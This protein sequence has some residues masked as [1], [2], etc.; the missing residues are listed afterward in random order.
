MKHIDY[1]FIDPF[2]KLNSGVSTYTDIA[3]RC[4]LNH[5][6]NSEI[7][8]ISKNE[9][10]ESFRKRLQ[11]Y[12]SENDIY[13]IESPETL[14]PTQY[15]KHKNIHIRLHCSKNVGNY[16][17][18]LPINKSLQQHEQDEINKARWISAPSSI[19]KI[20]TEKL[21]SLG[22]VYVY[23]NPCPPSAITS[24]NSTQ[25]SREKNIYF[26]G[27]G[28]QLKGIHF[29]DKI[30]KN[31]IL[32]GDV[33][34]KEYAK[35]NL[36]PDTKYFDGRKNDFLG[37]LNHGD[38]VIIL[39]LF[40][41]SSM[42]ALE[43]I[44]RGCKIISW[45]HIGFCEFFSEKIVTKIP[46]WDIVDFINQL[47][48]SMDSEIIE[49][50]YF[51]TEIESN[52][53]QFESGI[54]NIYKQ[55]NINTLIDYEL[56]VNFLPYRDLHMSRAKKKI[57]KLFRDPKRFFYDSKFTPSFLKKI[58][59]TPEESYNSETRNEIKQTPLE[60]ISVA[61]ENKEEAGVKINLK[62]NDFINLPDFTSGNPDL[63]CAFFYYK[64]DEETAKQI[65]EECSKHKDFKP[66]QTTNFT[67]ASYDFESIDFV[68]TFNK[69]DLTNK[70]K[71]SKIKNLFIL[72]DELFAEVLRACNCDVNIY[73]IITKE[74]DDDYQS[75]DGY[76]FQAT[77]NNFSKNIKHIKTNTA[78]NTSIAMRKIVQE[79]IK[80]DVC[81]PLPVISSTELIS[82]LV[83]YDTSNY[84]VFLTVNDYKTLI[85]S[86]NHNQLCQLLSTVTNQLFVSENAFN[87][88]SHLLSTPSKD[89]LEEFYIKA[90]KDGMRFNVKY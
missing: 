11:K 41:T 35:K 43:S 59:L 70:Q 51:I 16:V 24:N 31:I 37:C 21:Y 58:N 76:I 54:L 61:S 26:I 7:F 14:Y 2:G 68:K 74:L 9:G 22:N 1:L 4:L 23:P 88:Y 79:N 18:R 29:L 10:L 78:L 36:P 71:L 60:Q 30:K 17:Q 63:N 49:K 77:N 38:I 81:L 90:T 34:L 48:L 87:K 80:K 73:L 19:T 8:R 40:E 65:I 33:K 62:S 6:I 89:N 12:V 67:T 72:N 66:F 25:Q 42:V 85:K 55:K 3:N 28:E 27:R 45:K 83:S 57:L 84:D 82:D 46:P 15:V 47:S 64:D 56:D 32:I 86:K 75:L 44:S 50:K 69:I 5:K 20:I 39:S 52:N 53:N 13:I